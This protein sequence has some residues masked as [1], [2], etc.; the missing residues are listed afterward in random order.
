MA[1]AA[2]DSTPH[3]SGDRSSLPHA[4]KSFWIRDFGAYSSNPDLDTDIHCDILVIGGG[5]AGLSS[6]WHAAKSGLGKVVLIESEVIGFGASGRAAGWIMPQFGMDQ[7]SIRK[8]YGVERS[9]A[10]FAYCRRATAYTREII[11][12][13]GIE[14]DYRAPGLM[15][16]AFDDR[17][18][19]DLHDLYSTYQ[20]IGVDT[21]SWL[22]AP[23]VQ[24]HYNGNSNFKAAISDTDLG[25]LNPCKQVRALKALAEAAGVTVYE[26]TSA[27]HIERRPGGVW[28]I[29]PGGSIQASK[30][31]IATNAFTHQLQGP[32]GRELASY[33]APVF[34]R[35]AVTERLSDKQWAEVGW[36]QGNAIESS[37]DLFHYMAPTADQRIQFYFI[38]YGGHPVRNEMEP[39]VSAKGSDVSLAHLK[40]IFPALR[41][42]RLEHNW[43]GHMSATRDMV[44]HL[45][46]IGDQRVIYIGGC[47]GHGLAINHLHG[48]TVADMLAE[49]STDLTDFWIVDRKP[50]SWPVWPLD[51]IGKQLAWSLLKR[52][53]RKQIRG[54]IFEGCDGDLQ[55]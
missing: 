28:V 38:Y 49:R 47:W 53:V 55:E 27:T 39:A 16:V 33:Q 13:N 50:K 17:W 18:V 26:N 24:A 35:G 21:V 37:L 22:T 20:D 44:P 14:S 6:A 1:A 10:A 51:F 19:D 46:S 42:V 2:D 40:R 7:L 31:V 45:T 36:E 43:G 3:G 25:L 48:Q 52:K 23:D 15:R 11:E 41:D 32:V 54:S 8:A 4:G 29:T 34:A 5:I 30:V 9:R 12:Q